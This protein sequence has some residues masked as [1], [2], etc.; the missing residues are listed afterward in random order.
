MR[1]LTGGRRPRERRHRKVQVSGPALRL[2][3]APAETG[4][5]PM[6][7]RLLVLLVF[8]ACVGV[9]A[10][11]PGL[12]LGVADDNLKW[13]EDTNGIVLDQQAIGFKAV[14][15]TLTWQQ[16]QTKLDDNGRTY[17]RRAQ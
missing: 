8:F 13:T 7:L 4:R 14:R 17:M 12:L 5:P 6:R 9:A 1:A 16:G 2:R 15:V 11:G 10:A 3:P